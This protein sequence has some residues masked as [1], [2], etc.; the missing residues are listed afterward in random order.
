MLVALLEEDGAQLQ[1]PALQVWGKSETAAQHCP[2]FT[3]PPVA[4]HSSASFCVTAAWMDLGCKRVSR[5]QR[6]CGVLSRHIDSDPQ[7]D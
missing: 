5:A 4:V 1:A 2:V 3:T 6:D 7:C